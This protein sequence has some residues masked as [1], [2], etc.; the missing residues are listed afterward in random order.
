MSK[1]NMERIVSGS[2]C[3]EVMVG[4]LTIS[5][6]AIL[7][8]VVLLKLVEIGGKLDDIVGGREKWNGKQGL[9]DGDV[10]KG[11]QS[12]EEAITCK[13]AVTVGDLGVVEEVECRAT[14]VDERGDLDKN[15]ISHFSDMTGRIVA[16]P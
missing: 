11:E 13:L 8:G 2:Q 7:T 3:L 4:K 1:L 6:D 14:K 15:D 5:I 10:G 9:F 16:G 12:M